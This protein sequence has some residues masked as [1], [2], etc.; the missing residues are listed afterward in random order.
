VSDWPHILDLHELLTPADHQ[1]H[2][3]YPFQVPPDVCQLEIAVRYTPKRVTEPHSRALAATVLAQQTA[4][5]ARRVGEPRAMQWSVDYSAVAHRSRVAN[6]LTISLDDAHGVYR[7]AGHR[8]ADD[9]RLAL[10]PNAA[11]P[12]LVVGPLPSGEWTLTL[13]VHTL[14][15]DQCEVSIQIGAEMASTR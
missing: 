8:H 9:Q 11:S 3:R 15:S 5:F 13:S 14:V 4:A 7:G 12:G 1:T 6:L 10:G 2:R